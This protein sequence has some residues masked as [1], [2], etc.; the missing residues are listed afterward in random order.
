MGY[1]SWTNF[2]GHLYVLFFT[3]YP[4]K[5][6][7]QP[8]SHQTLLFWIPEDVESII[9]FPLDSINSRIFNWLKP[10]HTLYVNDTKN[11]LIIKTDNA[12]TSLICY[13]KLRYRAERQN[14]ALR[15]LLSIHVLRNGHP[16]NC[17]HVLSIIVL[18]GNNMRN[19]ALLNP[20]NYA[21][22]LSQSNY[23]V[24]LLRLK[25]QPPVSIHPVRLIS[26]ICLSVHFQWVSNPIAESAVINNYL[27]STV[28]CLYCTVPCKVFIPI[29]IFPILLHYN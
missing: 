12:F 13:M 10:D 3:D 17:N 19:G 20:R 29:G 14:C 18:L 8:W 22:R 9:D 16:W 1:N 4:F 5:Y 25:S 26:E 27:G 15:L 7:N 2:L 6:W 21:A 23:F 11:E 28:Q 24:T